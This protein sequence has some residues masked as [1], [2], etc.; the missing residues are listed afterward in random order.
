MT[1]LEKNIETFIKIINI[2]KERAATSALAAFPLKTPTILKKLFINAR[3]DEA[4]DVRTIILILDTALRE[5]R[6]KRNVIAEL[7]RP[8]FKITDAKDA[9]VIIKMVIKETYD[10]KHKICF[11]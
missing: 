9:L 10:R 8:R 6:N 5:I 4:Y 11:I 1:A 2:L 7:L 3:R